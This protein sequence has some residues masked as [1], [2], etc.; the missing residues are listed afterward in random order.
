ML[1]TMML[2]GSVSA[3]ISARFELDPQ[4]VVTRA[5]AEQSAWTYDWAPYYWSASLSGSLTIDGQKIDMEG[6]GDGGLGP[7]ALIGYLGHIEAQHGPWTIC[8]AP[9]FIDA[10]D[11][12]GGQPPSTDA[13]VTI[14][15]QVHE[16]FVAREFSPGWEWMLGARY[17]HIET[18][19]DLSVGGMPVASL[20]GSST[21][22]DP[23]VGL[24]YHTALG[25][26]WS[27]HCRGDIGGFGLGSDFVWNAS[28]VA[29]YKFTEL[30]GVTLGYR[31]LSYDFSEFDASGRSACSLSMFGPIIGLS[32]SF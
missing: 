29:N 17:Q 9:I 1:A 12:A 32:F 19:A 11:M 22:T 16:L 26:D 18:D 13:S 6:G 23:I 20:K 2:A 27:L 28:A 4:E 15:A 3:P 7:P 24:R 14:R 25:G 21:W 8:F 5:Q 30:F 10:S 31:A